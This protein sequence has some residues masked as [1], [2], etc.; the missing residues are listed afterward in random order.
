MRADGDCFVT[1]FHLFVLDEGLVT[2]P[3]HAR[4]V[5]GLVTHPQLGIK[6]LHAWV[7]VD[8]VVFDFSNGHRVIMDRA[9]YY[10]AGGIEEGDV[11]RYLRREAM[12][13]VVATK[14]Y[15]PWDEYLLDRDGTKDIDKVSQDMF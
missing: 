11:V 2:F 3:D 1:A 7:E 14:T 15:G 10:S 13:M 9:G 6:H 5:H 4:L 12:G 8:G